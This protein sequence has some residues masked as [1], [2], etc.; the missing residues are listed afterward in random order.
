MRNVAN[1][2]SV[3]D[4]G[5]LGG[6][7][8]VVTGGNSGIGFHT[9]LELGRAGAKVVVACRDAMRG[10]EA[11]MAFLGQKADAGTLP[12]L[13]AATGEV[14]SGEFFGPRAKLHM[15]GPPVE[16]RLPK[17]ANDGAT[18]RVL[19]EALERLTGITY[20][21]GAPRRASP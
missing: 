18:A 7:T 21:F 16:V 20:D 8:M 14:G 6:K 17:R 13:Y 15:N 10:A 5:R 12:S 1:D 11:T 3:A 19:W 4:L 2:W 9:A